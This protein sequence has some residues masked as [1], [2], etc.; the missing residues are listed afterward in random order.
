MFSEPEYDDEADIKRYQG[1]R[2]A[3]EVL[4]M[5]PPRLPTQAE[6]DRYLDFLADSFREDPVLSIRWRKYTPGPK[7]IPF[8]NTRQLKRQYQYTFFVHWMM[9]AALGWPIAVAVGR[10]AKHY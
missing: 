3:D 10:R 2:E 9:G 1:I 4:E 8:K 7:R 6:E 5:K